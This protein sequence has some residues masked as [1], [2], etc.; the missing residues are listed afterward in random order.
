[1]KIGRVQII[2]EVMQRLADISNDPTLPIKLSAA[3]RVGYDRM[4]EVIQ[5]LLPAD[6]EPSVWLLRDILDRYLLAGDQTLHGH[7]S[8][9]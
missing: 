3:A 8:I 9:A 7:D 6:E 2:C 1:M 4:S 5:S